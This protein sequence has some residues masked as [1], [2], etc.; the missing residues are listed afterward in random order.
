MELNHYWT[1]YRNLEE[2]FLELSR[3]IH[4]DDNQLNVYSIKIC[5]LVIRTVV[6]VESLSKHLYFTKGGD[7]KDNNQLFFDTDCIDYLE[8]LWKLS[9]K[10]VLVSSPH[11]Y[12][13]EESNTVLTPLKKAN[14]RGSSSSDWLR[15]YQAI[16]HNR[17]ANLKKGSGLAR[18]FRTNGKVMLPFFGL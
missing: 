3:S 13:E 14:K 5:E 2:E 9:K 4:I 16:K 15:A 10:K 6:E 7:K 11:L 1:V 18:I 12:L 8:S 17:A